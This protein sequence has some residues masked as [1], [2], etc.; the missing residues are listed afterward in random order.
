MRYIKKEFPDYLWLIDDD[1]D[2]S[3]ILAQMASEERADLP[4]GPASPANM[5][6]VL[7]ESMEVTISN[8][9]ASTSS[10]DAASSAGLPPLFRGIEDVVPQSSILYQI[11]DAHEPLGDILITAYSHGIAGLNTSP[12]PGTLL[13][14][15]SRSRP[16]KKAWAWKI[17]TW[18]GK[19]GRP[20]TEK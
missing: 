19:R 9:R 2:V 11:N 15:T 4:P 13:A 14:Q 12:S 8:T 10:M 16:Y 1:H 6:S 17:K 20:H 3:Q 5:D 18:F 7:E